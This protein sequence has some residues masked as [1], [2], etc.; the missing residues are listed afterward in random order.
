MLT[1]SSIYLSRTPFS[2]I[3]QWAQMTPKE[4]KYGLPLW[5]S[6]GR[7]S[8]AATRPLHQLQSIKINDCLWKQRTHYKL[9]NGSIGF[10][11]TLHKLEVCNTA[12]AHCVYMSRA[13][14]S[15]I[16]QWT[17]WIRRKWNIVCTMMKY[18][19]TFYRR[20]TTL[21]PAAKQ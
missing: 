7:R 12:Y 18:G 19:E 6:T 14:F 1:L 3:P 13:P 21:T 4:M 5:W 11:E 8:T 15:N 16:P 17:Q 10:I 2:N 20:H 9:E